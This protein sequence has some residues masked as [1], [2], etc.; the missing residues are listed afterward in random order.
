M[1]Q[2]KRRSI[3][4]STWVDTANILKSSRTVASLTAKSSYCFAKYGLLTDSTKKEI[5]GYTGPRGKVYSP[6]AKI[7]EQEIVMQCSELPKSQG[8]AASPFQNVEYEKLMEDRNRRMK[9]EIKDVDDY[10]I[11]EEVDVC[12]IGTGPGGS[13][14]TWALSERY[15]EQLKDGS[16][17]IVMLERGGLHTSDEFDQ[18]EAKLLPALYQ[19]P[20]RFTD[21]FGIALV[22]G[23]LVGGSAV[24]NDAICFEAPA[25]VTREWEVDIGQELRDARVYRKVRDMIHYKKIPHMAQ[26][27]NARMFENGVTP[28]DLREHF[29]LN[30]RNTNPRIP[31]QPMRPQHQLACVGCGCCHLGCRYNRKQT[32]LITFVPAAM[33]NGVRIFKNATVT[34]VLHKG[35]KVEGVR[36]KRGAL[37]RDLVIKAK[38]VIV[39]C[40]AVNSAQ[41]LLGS[42]IENPHLGRHISL[43]PA[44]LIFGVFDEKVYSDWGIP[45]TSSYEKYQFPKNDEKVFP[46]GF[47]YLIETIANHPIAHA[48]S[49]PFG[50]VR[51]KM[52]KYSNTACATVILHDK[53]VGEI[54]SRHGHITPL[55]YKVHQEDQIKLKHGIKEAARI[56]LAAG[57][58]E[59][60]TS[61]EKETSFRSLE[62]L[63]KI[64]IFNE[65]HLPIGPGE[66]LLGSAHSQGGCRMATTGEHGVVD[67]NGHS[68]DVEN[69]YVSD[70]SLFPTSLGV[71]PQVT[72]MA[73]ATKIGDSID[74]GS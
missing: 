24:L 65:D 20:L 52:R 69:L 26:H 54:R 74:L 12:V 41:L 21:D 63:D 62:D 5:G 58:Q 56:F 55:T 37:R 47:G 19:S 61:H 39:S 25:Q 40:G 64:D 38:K 10:D 50:K 8:G 35:G 60:F 14:A 4:P 57:A 43:H 32:P 6:P 33:E 16:K 18:R 73:L 66:I 49:L 23:S 45:M 51:E 31:H 36:V 30:Q 29:I 17:K 67:F 2:R 68:H 72:I 7:V 27:K 11:E 70:G 22:K 1:S 71:N 9:A 48:A 3:K 46:D 44:P 59:V 13:A 28:E 15:K 42:G 53:A 34:E